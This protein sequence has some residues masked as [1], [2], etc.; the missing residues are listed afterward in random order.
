MATVTVE[1]PEDIANRFESLDS[2]RRTIYEDFIIEQRQQGNL[3]TGEAADLLGIAYSEFFD[4]LGNKGLSFINAGPG[5]LED[6]YRD[7]QAI[8]DQAKK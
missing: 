6:S 8:M 4:L 2:L 5:E 3:S 1:I 7:F